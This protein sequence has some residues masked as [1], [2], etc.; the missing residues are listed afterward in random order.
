MSNSLILRPSYWASVSGGK[1]SLYMLKLILENPDKYP[2]NGVV[3]YELEIDYPF[4]KDVIDYMENECKKYNI[5]FVRLKPPVSWYEVLEKYGFP[6]GRVRWC[7]KE[8][9][10][11]AEIALINFLKQN[12]KYLIKYIGY[13]VDEIKRFRPERNITEIY[14]LA[15]FNIY[16]STILDWAKNISLFNDY[17]KYNKRCGCMFCPLS[18]MTENAYLKVFYPEQYNFLMKTAKETEKLL[19]IKMKKPV[20]VWNGN[21]KYNTEYRMNRI[22][23]KYEQIILN[24]KKGG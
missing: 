19:E 24:I 3:H 22:S 4:I 5:P 23:E 15:D 21:A 14:P 2:L 16:E 10:M 20:S 18:S 1:D 11:K 12:N 17:Y 6:T 13:C 8:Y 9:K 7:N